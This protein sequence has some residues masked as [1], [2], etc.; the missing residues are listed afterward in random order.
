MRLEELGLE[1]WAGEFPVEGSEVFHLP[2]ALGVL[3]DHTDA[4]M[5]LYGAYK[6]DHVVGLLPVFVTENPLGR[7]ALSPPPGMGI[8]RLGPLVMPASPKQSKQESVNRSFADLLVDELS[9]DSQRTLLRMECPTSYEDP[10]PFRWSG[11]DVD[12]SFTYVLDVESASLE[13]IMK[14]FSR[15]LRKEIRAAQDLPVTV[16]REQVD[17]ALRIY[18]DVAD[19]YSEQGERFP[20]SRAYVRDLVD[21]L[22]DRCRVYVARG[23]DGSY[24]G[25]VILLY[26]NDVASFWQG[27]VRSEYEGVSIN[28]LIHWRVIADIVEDPPVDS[29]RGYDLVGANTPRLCRYK[30]KFDADLVPYYAVETEGVPMS[31]AKRAYSL[32]AR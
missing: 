8:P 20:L 1:S 2:A 9:A 27:G 32:V 17:G 18:E 15:D 13:E 25:G 4:E 11:M 16:E 3:D 7:M 14:G 24:Q 10:R 21:A 28:S 31:V 23:P 22:D 29:V 30:A 12:Q 5:R 26:S 19:R 6:G